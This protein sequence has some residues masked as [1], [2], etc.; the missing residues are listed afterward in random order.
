M[1]VFLTGATGFV[2]NYVMDALREAG[3]TIRALVRTGSESKLPFSDGVEIV[4]GDVTRPGPWTRRMEGVGGVI[5]LVGIIREFPR[6]GITFERLH[7][8]A[9]TVVADA[10][11]N[12]GVGRFVHMSANGAA[13][14]GVS[15]YQTTKW[16]AERY[17]VATGLTTTIFR[18][19][20]IFGDSRGKMEFTRE[21]ARVIRTAP[22]MPVFGGGR[23]LLDPVAVADVA[24]CFVAALTEPAAVDRTFHLGGGNPLPFNEIIRRIAVGAGV[25][26]VTLFSIPVGVV[27][28][29]AALLG[30]FPF[31]PLTADQLDMLVAGN[32]PP[33]TDFVTAF[34][35]TPQLFVSENLRYLRA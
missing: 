34:G 35:V 10:A 13:P 12:A 21:L 15:A 20:V 31:F 8:T 33:E 9:T 30:R 6:R 27:R 11:R 18:P 3:H 19:S 2:G 24:R 5:H 26:D 25:G 29:V 16:R 32:V 17:L 28:P 23:Y 4:N 1:I 22:I 14:D 7:H